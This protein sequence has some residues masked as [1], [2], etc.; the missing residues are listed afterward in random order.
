MTDKA[1]VATFLY[2]HNAALFAESELVILDNLF[3]TLGFRENYNSAFGFNTSPRAYLVY[4]AHDY[5]T[6]KGGVSTGY[7]TPDINTTSK[8][9][10]NYGKNGRF[11]YGNPKLKPESS[12]N[13]EASLL[14]ETDWTDV[15]ITGFY[16]LFEDKIT[17]SGPIAQGE[18]LPNGVCENPYDTSKKSGGCEYNINADKAKTTG[19]EVFVSIKPIN[20]G[21]GDIGLNLN[22]T[23]TRSLITSGESKGLPLADIP[24]HNFNGSLNYSLTKVGLYLRGEYKANQLNMPGRITTSKQLQEAQEKNP[25]YYK[26]YFLLHLG[27]NYNITP[28]ITLHFGIYNLLNH[29]FIDYYA[30]QDGKKIS[31]N[32]NYAYIHEGRRYFLSLNMDF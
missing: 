29:N 7:K 9:L 30:V 17:S 3:L 13:F 1:G 4:N 25:K 5:I 2:Q 11:I 16:N 6:L 28:S 12:I 14:S 21:Y 31:Y 15:G 10:Y 24:E 23:F 26:P 32:N 8:G 20:I 22:Y 27:G 19:A 18:P